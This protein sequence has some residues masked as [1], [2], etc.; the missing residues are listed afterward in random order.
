MP[1]AR[2]SKEHY[3]FSLFLMA[4]KTAEFNEENALIR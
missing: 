4:P 2:R 1:V 3:G